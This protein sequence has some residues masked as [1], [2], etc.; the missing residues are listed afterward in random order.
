MKMIQDEKGGVLILRLAGQLVGGQEGDALRDT[1]QGAFARGFRN[2]LVDL[3]DVSW[4]NSTG[5]GILI[6]G[7]LCATANGG[8]LILAG[9][10][11]RIDSIFQVTRLNTVFRL[12][13][14]E[15]SALLKMAG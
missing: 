13:P 9:A 1:I 15:E 7:H 11:R 14:D 6:S 12:Y 3:R 5:L 10:S 2:V 8:G 4:V